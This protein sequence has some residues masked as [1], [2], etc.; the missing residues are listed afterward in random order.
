LSSVLSARA[1]R[2]AIVPVR[3]FGQLGV[4]P[5]GAPPPN[6]SELLSGDSLPRLLAELGQDFDVILFDTPAAA[7]CSDAQTV[8]F[9]AGSA[10]MLARKDRTRL[11]D[12][13][14]LVRQLEHAGSQLLGTVCN[15]F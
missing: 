13:T 8:A 3:E 12:T 1:G 15:A 10:L 14:R 9:R 2:E 4:L 11:S 6:P 5:A 7:S